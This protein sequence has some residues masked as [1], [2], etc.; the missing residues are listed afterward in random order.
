MEMRRR[1]DNDNDGE[2]VGGGG[3]RRE[4]GDV[5]ASLRHGNKCTPQLHTS[6][7][8]QLYNTRGHETSQH[9]EE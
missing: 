8:T 4:E 9:V 3:G 2:S 6:N 7:S 5:Q 1:G